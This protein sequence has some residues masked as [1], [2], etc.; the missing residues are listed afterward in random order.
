MLQ[1]LVK[2]I[3]SILLPGSDQRT[4]ENRIGEKNKDRNENN[5]SNETDAETTSGNFASRNYARWCMNA[6][7]DSASCFEPR[8][9]V[10]LP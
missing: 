8:E 1:L 2:T 5:I 4:K 3:N 6:D 10:L 9:Y 7:S